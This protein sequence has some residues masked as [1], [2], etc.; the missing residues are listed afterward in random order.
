MRNYEKTT[1]LL[2]L[3]AVL[4]SGC[5][6]PAT[7]PE[8]TETEKPTPDSSA[9][10]TLPAETTLSAETAA[11]P[12]IPAAQERITVLQNPGGLT[13]SDEEVVGMWLEGPPDPIESL[14]APDG[15]G[16]VFTRDGE[17]GADGIFWR[18]SAGK[19]TKIFTHV[20]MKK[21]GSLGDVHYA[22]ITGFLDDTHLVCSYSG[23][24]CFRG[25]GIYDTE[26]G[27]WSEHRH[28]WQIAGIRSGFVY[29]WEVGDSYLPTAVWR[30]D[31]DGTETK[32]AAPGENSHKAWEMLFTQTDVVSAPDFEGGM[33][34]LRPCE[35]QNQSACTYFFSEDTK[36][37]LAAIE[38]HPEAKSA[39]Y[40][41]DG[42]H[43]TVFVR[44]GEED[45][46]Q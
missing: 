33:W 8:H 41:I 30:I 31:A 24:E 4:L 40:L 46:V 45:H 14:D 5:L 22:S 19:E 9:G 18:D 38:W 16:T 43:V 42:G 17:D 44:V 25:C 11:P 34:I 29:A 28:N 35:G 15:S 13:F 21:G 32:L 10:T 26:T 39:E 12:E 27:I 3:T 20:P 1:A 36:T 37:L 2:A 7:P 23:Y 6:R